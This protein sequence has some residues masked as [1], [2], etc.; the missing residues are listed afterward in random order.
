MTQPH[1]RIQP[2]ANPAPLPPGIEI[3]S[4]R[5]PVPPTATRP[6]VTP[7]KRWQ[8]WAGGAAVVLALIIA[9]GIGRASAPASHAY[10]PGPG[11]LSGP[12]TRIHLY[13]DADPGA[14]AGDIHASTGIA[15]HRVH[16]S[17]R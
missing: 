5:G 1:D 14:V 8:W 2:P 11:G 10:R 16:R 3:P 6:P 12:H 13:R 15:G 4:Q 7:R 9:A 17:G